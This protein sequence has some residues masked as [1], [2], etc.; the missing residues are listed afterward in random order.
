MIV[1][2]VSGIKL[3][4]NVLFANLTVFIFL[5]TYIINL[6]IACCQISIIDPQDDNWN[7]HLLGKI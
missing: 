6:A 3:Q 2:F 7:I 1:T 4:I 5:G